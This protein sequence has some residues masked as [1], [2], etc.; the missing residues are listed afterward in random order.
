MAKRQPGSQPTWT[1][2]KAE[3]ASFDR[4]GLLGLIQDLYATHKDNQTFLHTRFGLGEDVLKPYKETLDRWLWPDVLRNQDTSVVKAKQAIS[5]YRKAV[6]EPAGLVEL[7]VFYCERAAGFCSDIGYQDDG[8]FDALVRMFKQ[9]LEAIA[10]L[11]A[12]TSHALIA[13]LDKVRAVSHNFGYGV[14]DDLDS[15]LAKYVR[16]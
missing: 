10:Q 5:N 4:R 12:S 16:E 3:L 7:M 11:P 15:L 14:G 9:A 13:R 2:V 1:D 8:Y 6:G